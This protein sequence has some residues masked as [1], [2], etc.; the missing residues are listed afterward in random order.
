MFTSSGKEIYLV[1]GIVR[2]IHAGLNDIFDRD[3][4]FTTDATPDEIKTIIQP[5]AEMCGFRTT[6]W[7][8]RSPNKRKTIE[9]TTHRSES[10]VSES[11][12][13][14]PFS[15]D[16]QEDLSRRISPSTAWLSILNLEN[17]LIHS[18]G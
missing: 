2:D 16:L 11:K 4:D 12:A 9:I 14:C 1:G 13:S 15:T 8:N 7:N 3:L 10:Y 18:M 5:I 17:L 6:I